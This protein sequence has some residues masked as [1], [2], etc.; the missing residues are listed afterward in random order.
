MACAEG[1]TERAFLV[2]WLRLAQFR[3]C[4]CDLALA[5]LRRGFRP[6]GVDG[7]QA[8][9]NACVRQRLVTL[10]KQMDKYTAAFE[11]IAEASLQTTQRS[12]RAT[13]LRRS[14]RSSRR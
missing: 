14:G 7:A 13:R 2:A 6:S 1:V 8:E 12:S 10:L 4:T 3:A 9:W 5:L 11:G